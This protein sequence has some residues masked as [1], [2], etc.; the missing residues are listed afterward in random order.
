MTVKS[1]QSGFTLVEIAIV[2][3]IVTILLGYTVALFPRQQ[4]LARRYLIRWALRTTI[5]QVIPAVIITVV[6]CR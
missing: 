2:L 6:S 4:Q 5:L 3:L 1:P